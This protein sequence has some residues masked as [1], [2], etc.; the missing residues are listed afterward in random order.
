MADYD[1]SSGDGEF[2]GVAAGGLLR[3]LQIS[4]VFAVLPDRFKVVVPDTPANRL[5]FLSAEILRE[6]K[7]Q[8]ADGASEA[9]EAIGLTT[10]IRMVEGLVAGFRAR[11]SE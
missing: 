5:E 9:E 2:N 1:V 11:L 6:V 7:N 4:V 3:A 8:S 10:A